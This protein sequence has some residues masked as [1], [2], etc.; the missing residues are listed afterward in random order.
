MRQANREFEEHSPNGFPSDILPIL[1]WIFYKQEKRARMAID[2]FMEITDKMFE[3]ARKSWIKGNF[4]CLPHTNHWLRTTEKSGF[5]F[6]LELPGQ[7][8][9][10]T[11]VLLNAREEF[12]AEDRNSA[13][14]LTDENL[15]QVVFDI[16]GAG[17]GTS[18]NVLCF[19]FLLLADDQELQDELRNE[20]LEEIGMDRCTHQNRT[21]LRK[22]DS[23]LQE[24][25][26]LYPPA[27]LA[28]PRKA[29]EDVEISKSSFPLGELSN[30]E[31]VG[32][33]PI[34]HFN[35]VF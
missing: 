10:F 14:Y 35:Y 31:N 5:L 34:Y 2:C 6:E 18:R 13:K 23:F 3:Q 17:T 19:C 21:R 24:T 7:N 32:R 20:I 12:L 11:D 27:P 15:R 26:R 33:Q 30:E 28:L 8:R 29:L 1:G 25:I 9:Q 16:F 4:F 22:I